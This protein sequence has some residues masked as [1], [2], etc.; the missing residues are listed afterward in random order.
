MYSEIGHDYVLDI[1]GQIEYPNT[2][3]IYCFSYELNESQS[4]VYNKLIVE[5]N[6]SGVISM[7]GSQ[8]AI[9]EIQFTDEKVKTN[10]VYVAVFSAVFVCAVWFSLTMYFEIRPRPIVFK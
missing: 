6:L 1:R 5:N 4:T 9:T 3:Q 7:Y 2:E 10:F 8:T